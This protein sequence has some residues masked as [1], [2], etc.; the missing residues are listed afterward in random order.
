MTRDGHAAAAAP[1]DL[2][3]RG[4]WRSTGPVT[5]A[6]RVMGRA[7]S[8]RQSIRVTQLARTSCLHCAWFLTVVAWVMVSLSCVA[9]PHDTIALV[10]MAGIDTQQFR[11]TRA[12]ASFSPKPNDPT[13]L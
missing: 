12:L 4:C 6:Q 7:R 8:E 11:S 10:T 9:V 2:E 3:L 5:A 13:V 1:A